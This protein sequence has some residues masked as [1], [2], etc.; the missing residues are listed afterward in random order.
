MNLLL[1]GGAAGLLWALSARRQSAMLKA[2][3]TN[4]SLSA[5]GLTPILTLFM[6]VINPSRL[7]VTIT[8]YSGTVELLIPN[9]APIPIG[10]VIDTQRTTIEAG[11][12]SNVKIPVRLNPN[13]L[14][15]LFGIGEKEMQGL[16][17]GGTAVSL[18]PS[19]AAES[20]IVSGNPK[21][22]GGTGTKFQ[23]PNATLPT[24]VVEPESPRV[25]RMEPSLLKEIGAM[26]LSMQ[27]YEIR[28]KVQVN[29]LTGTFQFE[30]RQ[31]IAG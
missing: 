1:I 20:V 27:G 3:V 12:E 9:K 13:A 26:A 4:I 15:G 17:A 31:K 11:K 24:V 2:Y 25:P 10:D 23:A 29:T 8:G 22:S 14:I 19:R 28:Y 7:S 16:P 21:A 30:G 6:N 18:P 5:Q